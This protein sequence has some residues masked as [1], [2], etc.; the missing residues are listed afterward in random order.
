MDEEG[1]QAVAASPDRPVLDI[2]QE[3]LVS[4]DQAAAREGWTLDLPVGREVEAGAGRETLPGRPGGDPAEPQGFEQAVNGIQQPTRAVAVD[5][6]P[7]GRA[8]QV[9]LSESRDWC[10]GIDRPSSVRLSS[11]RDTGGR[12][13]V[14]GRPAAR[15]PPAG[16]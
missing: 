13:G 15:K 12:S 3:G 6:D 2:F 10:P 8:D 7:L 1:V 5:I 9:K 4:Q 16:R 11:G 14:P